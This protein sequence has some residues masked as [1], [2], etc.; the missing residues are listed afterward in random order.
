[1]ENVDAVLNM[2]EPRGAQLEHKRHDELCM[3]VREML[4][5]AIEHGGANNPDR[6]VSLSCVVTHDAV[7]VHITDPG[8]GFTGA[9]LRHAAV[10][11]PENGNALE[12][13]EVRE[14]QGIRPGGFGILLAQRLVDE[15]I[16]NEK[17]NEVLLVKKL[18]PC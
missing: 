14:Q 16:Y 8:N 3:A 6:S 1:M 5:N 4:M 12:H 2:L 11:Y 15:L 13:L 18:H 17:G 9:D 10:G 7:L